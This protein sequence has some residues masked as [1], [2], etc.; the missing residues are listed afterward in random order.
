MS[1]TS[2]AKTRFDNTKRLSIFSPIVFVC[3]ASGL[4]EWHCRTRLRL[5][6]SEFSNGLHRCRG[7]VLRTPNFHCMSACL[8]LLWP[9]HLRI[10]NR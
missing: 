1:R 7:T 5:A 2:Q 6:R 3:C 8:M 9:Q 4:V 10:R